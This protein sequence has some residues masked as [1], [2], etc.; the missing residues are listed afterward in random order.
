MSDQ[1][2]TRA[3]AATKTFLP[4]PVS[5]FLKSVASAAAGPMIW[6]YRTGFLRSC[7]ARAAVSRKGSAL[8]WYT[9]PAID[10]L[11]FRNF[12]SR[13]IL[14]FGGGQSSVWWAKRARNV[15]TLEGDPAWFERI[16]TQMPENVKLVLVPMPD[17]RTNV[18]AVARVLETQE[19]PR[20]DVAVI[21]GLYRREMVDFALKYRSADGVVICDNSDGYGFHERLQDSGLSRVDFHGNAPGLALP[22]VTSMYF[23]PGNCFLF[24]ARVPIE[25]DGW[26]GL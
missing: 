7:F 15:L 12:Q 2:L 22:N 17:V 9:Y 10:F 8:P 18:E 26:Q 1:W 21:D 20:F 6:A 16:R 13:S 19:N 11:R 14:E 24:D 5:S 3:F 25:R 23:D 4:T